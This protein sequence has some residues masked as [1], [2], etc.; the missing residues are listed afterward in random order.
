[1]VIYQS[2]GNVPQQ[3]WDVDTLFKVGGLTSDDWVSGSYHLENGKVIQDAAKKSSFREFWNIREAVVNNNFNRIFAASGTPNIN[4]EG[5]RNTF[6]QINDMYNDDVM[7]VGDTI[8]HWKRFGEIVENGGSV[9][10]FD[11]E[12]FGEATQLKLGKN[13]DNIYGITEIG[14]G[15]RKYV[16][17]VVSLAES[18]GESYVVGIARNTAEYSYLN[19]VIEKFDKYGW[20]A[21]SKTEKVTA[22]RLSMYAAGA[23]SDSKVVPGLKTVTELSSPTINIGR[24]RKGLTALESVEQKTAGDVIF[25]SFKAYGILDEAGNLGQSF[26]DMTSLLYGANVGF[27]INVAERALRDAGYDQAAKTVAGLKSQMLDVVATPRAMAKANNMSVGEWFQKVTG[28]RSGASVDSQLHAYGYTEGQHH[29]AGGLVG[30]DIWNEGNLLDQHLLQMKSDSA[31]VKSLTPKVTKDRISYGLVTERS[32]DR[33][34]YFHHGGLNGSTGMEFGVIGETPIPKISLQGQFWQ[35][36]QEH[37]GM[38][39]LMTQGLEGEV[40]ENKFVLTLMDYADM[41]DNPEHVNRVVIVR[42][43]QEDAYEF[44]KENATSFEDQ[45]RISDKLVREQKLFHQSDYARRE[46]ERVIN[47]NEVR[48]GDFGQDV[49]GVEGLK[50]L[51][52]MQDTLGVTPNTTSGLYQALDTA[53]KAGAKYNGYELQTFVGLSEKLANERPL[54]EDILA[55]IDKSMPQ[56]SNLEKTIAFKK[57][58]NQSVEYMRSQYASGATRAFENISDRFGIDVDL[59]DGVIKRINASSAE[60]ARSSVYSLLK[61]NMTNG[62]TIDKKTTMDLFEQLT[63]RGFLDDDKRQRLATIIDK[64]IGTDNLWGV[65]DDLGLELV[66]HNRDE[67]R[68]LRN[69]SEQMEAERIATFRV[70][71]SKLSLGDAYLKTTA[72]EV[73]NGMAGADGIIQSAIASLPTVTPL[74]GKEG[75]FASNIADVASHLNITRKEDVDILKSLFIG[76]EAGGKGPYKGYALKGYEE[77]GLRS[78]LI[79]GGEGRSSYIAVTREQDM[80]RFL[81]AIAEDKFDF[82]SYKKLTSNGEIFNYAGIAEL[83]HINEYD[84]IGEG[85]KDLNEVQQKLR[86]GVIQTVNQGE[87]HEVFI[88]P[89]LNI[90]DDGIQRAYFNS[91][92]WDVY[93]SLRVKMQSAIGKGLEG[94]YHGF[95]TMVRNQMISVLEDMPSSSTYRA[96]Q[97]P[98][99]TIRRMINFGPADMV[100]ASQADIVD[101]LETIF[102]KAVMAPEADEL[103]EVVKQFIMRSGLDYGKLDDYA[104]YSK[105]I[106]DSSTG[107]QEY[108][109]KHLFIG[110]DTDGFLG[111]IGDAAGISPTWG[112]KNFFQLIQ[113]TV[114]RDIANG[115]TGKYNPMFDKSVAI[116]LDDIFQAAGGDFKNIDQLTGVRGLQKG[117]VGFMTSAGMY[118]PG[119]TMNNTMRPVYTQQNNGLLFLRSAME[120]DAGLTD[121]ISVGKNALSI[122]EYN[123]KKKM[124][125]ALVANG[126]ELPGLDYMS[127]ERNFLGR[128]KN[129]NDY[130]LQR[131]FE[132]LKKEGAEL[133]DA[134]G[135][136]IFQSADEAQRAWEMFQSNYMSLHEGSYL[137][138]PSFGDSA[139]MTQREAMKMTMDFHNVDIERTRDVLTGI[140][141]GDQ[142][143]TRDTV[144]GIDKY[145]K[146]MYYQGAEARFT[147]QNLLELLPEE[148]SEKNL[149]VLT[150]NYGRTNVM[151]IGRGDF[152]VEKLFIDGAEKG[153]GHG[154]NIDLFMQRMGYDKET[155]YRIANGMFSRL[156]DNAAVIA[157]LGMAKHVVMGEAFS[158]W[159]TIV[160]EYAKAG[161]TEML[162]N[163]LKSGQIDT[164]GVQFDLQDGRLLWNDLAAD[165]AQSMIDN[166]YK[167][168]SSGQ[169]NIGLDVGI[170][171]TII[172]KVQEMT[173]HDIIYATI[174]AQNINEHMGTAQTIDDRIR[175]SMLLRGVKG[176]DGTF[177]IYQNNEQYIKALRNYAETYT[178]TGEGL[179]ETMQAAVD[180]ISKLRNGKRIH[181]TRDLSEVQRSAAGI[182]RS[183]EGYFD[184]ARITSAENVIDMSLTD[185]IKKGIVPKGGMT[186]NELEQ[187]IFYITDDAGNTRPSQFLLSLVDG[188]AERLKNKTAIRLDLESE[189]EYMAQVG[190]DSVKRKT[191]SV[192]LPIQNT[193]S[194]RGQDKFFIMEQQS[195]TASFLSRLSD[196]RTNPQGRSEKEINDKIAH[197]YDTYERSIA[198]QLETMNKD[199]DLYKAYNQYQFPNSVQVIARDEAAPLTKSLVMD[200]RLA[201]AYEEQAR[202]A[203]EIATGDHITDPAELR[204]LALEL[205]AQRAIVKEAIGET[206]EKI[207]S[208][209]M[210]VIDELSSLSDKYLARASKVQIGD[211]AYYGMVAAVSTDVLERQ[212]LN[213]NAVAMD[214]IN[215]YESQKFL[216]RTAGSTGMVG[217]E[218]L[219]PQSIE[220]ERLRIARKINSLGLV[221]K[222]GKALV[223]DTEKGIIGQLD[224]YIENAYL[225]KEIKNKAGEVISFE[226]PENLDNIAGKLQRAINEEIANGNKG[227]D[228]LFSAFSVGSGSTATGLG[229]DYMEQIGTYSNIYRYPVFNGQ[230]V[231]KILLSRNLQGNE[232]TL[233]NHIF[234]YRTHVDFDGDTMFLSTILDGMSVMKDNARSGFNYYQLSKKEYESFV[235]AYSREGLATAL[236]EGIDS[237]AFKKDIINSSRMQ[238]ASLLETFREGMYKQAF[239]DFKKTYAS[240]LDGVS[241]EVQKLIFQNSR[242]ISEL[243]DAE[244]INMVT[245]EISKMSG[246]A[247]RWRNLNIGSVS[248]PNYAL[249]NS[250]IAV[251]NA[252][253]AAGG[254]IVEVT[255]FNTIMNSLSNV[256]TEKGGLLSITEQKAIDT[257]KAAD[258]LEIARTGMYSS[259]MSRLVNAGKWAR[260]AK[261]QPFDEVFSRNIAQGTS[262]FIE[263]AGPNV[264]KFLQDTG[265]KERVAAISEFTSRT[266]FEDMSRILNSDVFGDVNKAIKRRD[267]ETSKILRGFQKELE[268]A[269]GAD[270]LDLFNKAFLGKSGYELGLI[271]QMRT[272]RGV[273]ELM[274]DYDGA[275]EMA[276]LLTKNVPM[277]ELNSTLARIQAMDTLG[278][279]DGTAQ[280][281]AIRKLKTSLS[282]AS[283]DFEVNAVYFA[284]GSFETEYVSR[285]FDEKTGKV[286]EHTGQIPEKNLE[287]LRQD[288]AYVYEGDDIF[289]EI[290]LDSGQP[291]EGHRFRRTEG[292]FRSRLSPEFDK[293]SVAEYRTNPALREKAMSQFAEI[294]RRT[295]LDFI[296]DGLGSMSE[297]DNRIMK[298]QLLE[299]TFGDDAMLVSRFFTDPNNLTDKGYALVDEGVINRV[300]GMRD[301]YDLASTSGTIQAKGMTGDKVLRSLNADIAAHPEWHKNMSGLSGSYDQFLREKMVGVFGSEELLDR[302]MGIAVSVPEMDIQAY[303]NAI[304]NLQEKTYNI[305]A[306]RRALNSAFDTLQQEIDEATK[307][308]ATTESL[309]PLRKAME[310]RKSTVNQVL[311]G[312]ELE[313][314]MQVSFAEDTIY[315]LFK[316]T[317]SNPD[318]FKK[319]M[320]NFFNWQEAGPT[321]IVGFGQHIGRRFSDLGLDDINAI[322]NAEVKATNAQQ[323]FAVEQTKEALGKYLASSRQNI[324]NSTIASGISKFHTRTIEQQSILSGLGEDVMRQ[325]NN[326]TSEE[327]RAAQRAAEEA[328]K[329]AGEAIKRKTVTGELFE[330]VKSLDITPKKVVGVVGAL[331]AI[332]LVNNAMHKGRKDSPLMPAQSNSAPDDKPSYEAPA[333]NG[334]NANT[335]Q[336]SVYMDKPSGLQ[337]KVSAKTRNKIDAQNNAKLL[338]MAGQ[339]SGNINTYADNSRVSDNWLA[340]KFAEL[341]G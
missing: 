281:M 259:G 308:G 285:V 318:M 189:I 121:I 177:Q 61:N 125:A 169:S 111:P 309:E 98:D 108:F 153:V 208:G 11:T 110:F 105:V 155:A 152:S 288:R 275:L 26:Q 306:Q 126:K 141:E 195:A 32:I 278:G 186:A 295:D 283:Q 305:D 149:E 49:R 8:A 99:G 188:D 174:Q 313:N 269:I 70:G 210:S 261:K 217:V 219:D 12:T 4:F 134:S 27:D 187:S 267:Q 107:F 147:K 203:K 319:G 204:R 264:F 185:F 69:L 286:I 190:Q 323:A 249:R 252:I 79:D 73:I 279:L 113:E 340:N 19:G 55:Q 179:P 292:V 191:R 159:N 136:R 290:S 274:S 223:L 237:A 328:S 220:A 255:K 157:N 47:P 339:N 256:L 48:M 58:Y 14:L 178:A 224:E 312:I 209:D 18:R 163:F 102:K 137:Y 240:T 95:T 115:L 83:P 184:P 88:N 82:S 213:F 310:N 127:T 244:K 199:S 156:S 45:R 166:L 207:R 51:L 334:A 320:S 253:D 165:N 158:K 180:S 114:N 336:R 36:D 144:I 124:A 206:A 90:T 84:I 202:I 119:S 139:A 276:Q 270:N 60:E 41:K 103:H 140:A 23:I 9:F 81:D 132:A 72:R 280:D 30:S 31:A 273:A 302:Y 5:M 299:D 1:M 235:Q 13:T 130:E 66:Q 138:Q 162:Y 122:D 116:A 241:D 118:N 196:L 263:G 112:S 106:N 289:R 194:V 145:G 96:M 258:A 59:G 271:E 150:G 53:G 109:R 6:M 28:R 197:L 170:N 16:N 52:A 24:M 284:P 43:S 236:E 75:A 227:V 239:D 251:K 296:T 229:Y 216:G 218:L 246:I 314:A 234:T 35:V 131:R 247:A 2:N 151:P 54:I 86:L 212:G 300:R 287:I 329:E 181:Q 316:G 97:M 282:M 142:R 338:G 129:M 211:Q 327:L 74:Y 63:E 303:K 80:G 222:E 325:F 301:A 133:T 232:I 257:K 22:E 148:L 243:F 39:T 311:S 238:K 128:V 260:N 262:M 324:P 15:E 322:L 205:D 214:V 332:G 225:K 29:I 21:L 123:A 297:I 77:L 67:G 183:V 68:I 50:K 173:E 167:A 228:A 10:G 265:A 56:A 46:W 248:T 315:G 172:G 272:L 201:A 76:K 85:A 317:P 154:M 294:R 331:A 94:D 200:E 93:G 326:M 304:D 298:V 40:E 341:S 38:T 164:R 20:E 92:V 135:R 160:D 104:Q 146:P 37:T 250:M 242:E 33:P 176:E 143:L 171:K 233:A 321:S 266:S 17:G 71:R 87:T 268:S 337:F 3:Q 175:Q 91:G 293:V 245:D 198:R 330:K 307:L 25:K 42:D 62:G 277:G 78:F 161:K 100:Q 101:G 64:S 221:D 192:L 65:S 226:L 230:P 231:G 120:S 34:L 89:R 57:A 215:E 168:V 291:V 193:A 333:S 44:L 117:R 182:F 335:G 254:D 7:Q